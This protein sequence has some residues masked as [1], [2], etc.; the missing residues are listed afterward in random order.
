MAHRKKALCACL[1][2]IG[3]MLFNSYAYAEEVSLAPNDGEVVQDSAVALYEP[4]ESD[5]EE[6]ESFEISTPESA[7]VLRAAAMPRVAS[8]GIGERLDGD[9]AYIS[10]AGLVTDENTASEYAIS[11]G[12]AP[13]DDTE[14]AGNDTSDTDNIVRSFDIVSYTTYFRTK[15]RDDA[16]YKAYRTGTLHFQFI[17]PGDSSQAQYEIDSM[18]WLKSKS[19]AQY[20]TEEITDEDSGQTY[21][22]LT[23]SFLL[24]PNNETPSAIGESYQE[25]NIAIRVLAMHN[26]DTL[27][28]SFTYWLEGNTVD[29]PCEEHGEKEP[30]TITPPEITVTA[31]PR[32][33]IQLKTCDTRAAYVGSFDFSTGNDF[34]MNKNAGDVYG[35]MNV[36]GITVQIMGKSAELGL[37]GCEIP[38]SDSLTFTLTLADKF[39]GDDGTTNDTTAEYAPL[40][41]SLEGN[42]KNDRSQ[43]QYDERALTGAYKFAAGGAPFNTDNYDYYTC[44]NGGTWTGT[45]IGDTVTITVS[46]YKIDLNKLP[47]TDSNSSQSSHVYYDPNIINIIKNYWKVQTACFSAGELWL[48]QPF[49]NADG[50]YVVDKYGTG[51]FNLTVTD[52]NLTLEDST[53]PSQMNAEDDRRTLPMDLEQPGSIDHSVTYQQYGVVEY[54]T[55]LTDGCYENGKDWV[56]AGGQLG[57]QEMLKHNTA[58]GL[59]TGVAYDDLVKFDDAFFVIEGIMLGSSAGMNNMKIQYLYGAKPDK[60]G[61]DHQDLQPQDAGYDAEMMSATADDLIFF[62]SLEEL[63]NTGYTCVAVL[64]EVRGLASAQS[65]NCYFALQGHV[66]DTAQSNAVY[67]VTHSAMAWNKNNV[68]DLAAEYLDKEAAALTDENYI[69]YMQSGAFPSRAD[70]QPHSYANEYAEAFWN[71]NTKTTDGLLNYQKVSYDASGYVNG[72]AGVSYG[73]SCL[74]VTYA[75]KLTKVVAQQSG[76]G[77]KTAYDMDTNQRI[78]D[79]VLHPSIV[80]TAGESVTG[81]T[82][83]TT[84]LYIEDTLPAGLHYVPGSAYW[85]GTYVQSAEG[86]QGTVQ[87]GTPMEPTITANSDGTTTLYWTLP[88]VAVGTA[89]VTSVASVYYSCSIGTPGEEETDVKNNDQLLNTAVIWG[90]AEQKRDFTAANGNLAEM[91]ILVTKNNAISLVKLAD[92][93][94]VDIGDE[95]GFTLHIGNNAVNSMNV[96]AVDTL[97]YNGDS[98]GSVFTGDCNVTE[99]TVNT[100]ELL[101]NI[102]LYATTQESER[103]KTSADYDTNSFTATTIWQELTVDFQ[104]GKVT[105]PQGDFKPVAIAAVGTLPANQTLQLHITLQLPDGQP[106]DHVVNCLTRGDLE[107]DANCYVVS[108]TLE[109]IVWLDA[110]KNG[111][112]SDG[113]TPVNGVTV[114]L[115]KLKDGGNAE[116]ESDYEPYYVS[117]DTPAQTVCGQQMNVITGEVSAYETGHYLFTNLPA[118]TFGVKF[119]DGTFSL[120]GYQATSVDVGD[121]TRDSD[122]VPTYDGSDARLTQGFIANIS[123]PTAEEMTTL[124]YSSKYHDMGLYLPET[125]PDTGLPANNRSPYALVLLPA[126]ALLL[127]ALHKRKRAAR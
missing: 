64:I 113:E 59:N 31:A 101:N 10:E 114:T 48:V 2:Y 76:S 30:K 23:G 12:T 27:Q 60:T 77:Q 71:N 110:D 92:Q 119:S 8:A 37:R 104:S 85:G 84:E 122:A 19:E 95:M 45:Q 81:D 82:S 72:S 55:A 109:G 41:W 118:G 42:D 79:Y 1:S 83:F 53:T 69:A 3:L 66:A 25:L 14:G 52:G 20:K 87:D 33:N 89:E 111:Q 93:S 4:L 13:W 67:M 9:Y 65:T 123:M 39:R 74:V 106:G 124:V 68:R 88:N 91:S 34:A 115:M 75:T 49:Y 15:V 102:K 24:E 73:D 51:T 50:E 97:P 46:G 18:G 35:R 125:A 22:V 58:E 121:D 117:A 107:S 16:P 112:R 11:T 54:G 38:S 63:Q 29:I 78:V 98:H 127:L 26:G 116:N 86:K 32:Y 96:I 90:S 70:G 17:L 57:I 99:I 62:T 44:A 56:V 7:A 36:L 43:Y 100:P 40:V 47:Y 94:L 28:P 126:G 80:R 120:Y 5:R 61:W 103:S 21:Q 108:R 6:S 105:L